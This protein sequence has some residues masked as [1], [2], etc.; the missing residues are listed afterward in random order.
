[1][2]DIKVTVCRNVA[3]RKCHLQGVNNTLEN[4]FHI[5]HSVHYNSVI[6]ILTKNAY[7]L[8]LRQY[9]KIPT[10]TG[11]GPYWSIIREYTIVRNCCLMLSNFLCNCVQLCYKNVCGCSIEL[12]AAVL[13][14]CEQLLYR[15]VCSYFYNCVQLFYTIVCRCFINCV[16]LICA[17][18][19]SCIIL[20]SAAVLY[21]CVQVFY[22][23]ECRCFVQLCA[24]VL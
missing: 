7:S 18:E 4:F 16:Q 21:H 14:N 2:H 17:I 8:K 13:Y 6:T 11:F 9:Y 12:C 20:F 23:I 1:M 5:P 10:P 24:A 22:K 15:I 3:A 19:R